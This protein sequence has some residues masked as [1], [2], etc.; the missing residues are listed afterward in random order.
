[1]PVSFRR[2]DTR[3]VLFL[4]WILAVG[5]WNLLHDTDV[6]HMTEDEIIMRFPNTHFQKKEIKKILI[7]KPFISDNI[8]EMESQCLKACKAKCEIYTDKNDITN[9]DAINF[10]LSG[11][12]DKYWSIGTR[13]VIKLPKYRR[14]DQVWVISNMEPPQ[15]L[16]GDLKVFNGL[17]NWTQWYRTD[18][19]IKWLYGGPY[20]LNKTEEEHAIIQ[21]SKRNIFNEKSR[22][23]CGRISNCMDSNRRYTII[24]EMQHYLDIDMY[25]LCYNHPCGNTRHEQDTSCNNVIKQY[26]FYLAFENNDCKDYVTEKYWY[27][28]EREQIPIVNWKLLNR[29]MVIPNSFINIYDFKDIESLTRYIK[30]VSENETLYNS[31]FDWKKTYANWH[32]C[33]ACQ[34]CEALHDKDRTAQVYED[35][36]SWVRNDICEKVGVGISKLVSLLIKFIN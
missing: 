29:N 31:Y 20:K 5:I 8:G 25:G 11:L 26:K 17:F 3:I 4:Y 28:L 19:D 30:E 1:M 2:V 27:S 34:I 13:S 33:T 7:W 36:D 32:Q 10:H 21:M 9:A 23:I 6:R 22:E 15:H 24:S 12:W 16:W 18:S 35:F 14:P